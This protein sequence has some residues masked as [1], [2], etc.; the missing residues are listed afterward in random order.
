MT[1]YLD[2]SPQSIQSFVMSICEDVLFKQDKRDNPTAIPPT[3]L[4]T[5]FDLNTHSVHIWG[6][7]GENNL[8]DLGIFLVFLIMFYGIFGLYIIPKLLINDS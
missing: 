7:M 4:A 1:Q 6:E 8:S 5:T 2:L 3:C